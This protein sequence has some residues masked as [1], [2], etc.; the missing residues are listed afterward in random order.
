[1][2]GWFLFF[3]LLAAGGAGYYFYRYEWLPTQDYIRALER[4]HEALLEKLK[5][6]SPPQTPARD[7]IV[8]PVDRIFRPGTPELTEA[9]KKRLVEVIKRIQTFSPTQVEVEAH[10]DSTP[11]GKKQRERFPTN[12]ELSAFRATAVTRYLIAQGLPPKLFKAISL[13]DTRPVASNR[14]PEG[15]RKNRRIV[16]K[17][18]KGRG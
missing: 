12:W 14:T 6:P 15:R 18:Y 2:K 13:A 16:I 9:G 5:N 17:L 4:E 10:A 1:M 8:I 3:L 7:S 11:V